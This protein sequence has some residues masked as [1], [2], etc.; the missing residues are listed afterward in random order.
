M[1]KIKKEKHA[2][3]DNA[4]LWFAGLWFAGLCPTPR[5]GLSPLT[6]FRRNIHSCVGEEISKKVVFG[7]RQNRN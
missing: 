6:R 1:T 4:G 5:K 3:S 7:S 2:G